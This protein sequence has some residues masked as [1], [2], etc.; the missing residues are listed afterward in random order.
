VTYDYHVIVE[1]REEEREREREREEGHLN[2]K[3]D[4][5]H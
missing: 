4:E 2:V 1:Q 3:N 5:L